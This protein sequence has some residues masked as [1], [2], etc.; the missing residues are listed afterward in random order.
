MQRLGLGAMAARLLDGKKETVDV[1]PPPHIT[2][3]GMSQPPGRRLAAA[4]QK[5]ERPKPKARP[6]SSNPPTS[7]PKKPHPFAKFFRKKDA[8]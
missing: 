5:P 7:D 6:A 8:D 2:P 4:T 3:C 1:T